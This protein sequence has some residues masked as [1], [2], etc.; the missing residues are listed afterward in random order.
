MRDLPTGLSTLL[1]EEFQSISIS[2]TC[3][4]ENT[5]GVR[6]WWA[7]GDTALLQGLPSE[8]VRVH[9]IKLTCYGAPADQDWPSQGFCNMCVALLMNNRQPPQAED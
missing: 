4:T 9:C 2:S 5:Q 8:G 3:L 7:K 1:V 6:V